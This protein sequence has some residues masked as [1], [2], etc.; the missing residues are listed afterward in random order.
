LRE[1]EEERLREIEEARLREIEEARLREIEEARLREI[2]ELQEIKEQERLKEVEEARMREEELQQINKQC[3]TESKT[4][5]E[6]ESETELSEEIE[7]KTR[8]HK[9]SVQTRIT[10]QQGINI[11]SKLREENEISSE[12]IIDDMIIAYLDRCAS[13]QVYSFI[14]YIPFSK[15]F[16]LLTDL[17]NKQYPY[18]KETDMK[19][20]SRL[21]KFVC[22]SE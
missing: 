9:E 11:L 19:E 7:P 18:N 12:E 13:D 17:I 6:T 2:E 15:K 20:G 10:V 8:K 4:E 3:D 14:K 5:S 1:I 22:N 21:Y 16:D